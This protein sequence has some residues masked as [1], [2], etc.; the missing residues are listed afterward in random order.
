MTRSQMLALLRSPDAMSRYHYEPGHLTASGF[1][2]DPTGRNVVLVDHPKI[3]KW[4]QPGGHIE[5]DDLDLESAARREIEE[6]TGLTDLVSL[7]LFDLDIHTFPSHGDQPTHLHFD[8]RFAFRSMTDEIHAGDH[9][10]A[11]IE[12]DEVPTWNAE[13]SVTRPVAKL[14]QLVGERP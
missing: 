13:V 8:V 4:L 7:G 2:L 1:V 6:E 10:A 11:W 12:L 14:R 5:P 3:G 9:Q